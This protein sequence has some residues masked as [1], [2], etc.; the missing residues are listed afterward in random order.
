M[1]PPR[2][3]WDRLPEAYAGILRRCE[4]LLPEIE[5]SVASMP[6]LTPEQIVRLRYLL[7]GTTGARDE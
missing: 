3:T 4:A 5:A 2:D 1:P 6:P 7:Y